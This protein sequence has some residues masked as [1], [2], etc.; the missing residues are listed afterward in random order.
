MLVE[1]LFEF[2]RVCEMIKNNETECFEMI[3]L[4]KKF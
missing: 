2:M 3:S 1:D 4:S